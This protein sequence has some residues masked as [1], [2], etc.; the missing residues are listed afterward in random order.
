MILGRHTLCDLYDCKTNKLDDLEFIEKMLVE[1]CRKANLTV[2]E[3]T[4][5]KFEPIG[6][7]G[8]VVLAESHVTIHTWP[9]YNFASID[10]FTCGENMSPD[11][12]CKLIGESLNSKHIKIKNV[13]RGELKFNE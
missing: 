7:S 11:E 12:V 2:V 6:I 9:E 1:C 4:F 13:K 5:H 10:A 8:V 3:V